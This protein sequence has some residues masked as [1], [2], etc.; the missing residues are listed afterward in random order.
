MFK[1]G[2]LQVLGVGIYETLYMTLI[3]TLMS[4][5]I[6]LPIGLALVSTDKEGYFII[7]FLGIKIPII[8]LNKLLG[9][10]VNILRSVPFLILLIAVMPVTRAIVGTTIG[11]KATI[12]PLVI[13]AAPFIARMVESSLKEVDRGVIEAAESMGASPFQI[14]FKVHLPEAKPSLLVGAAISITTILGYSAMAGIVGGG[15]LGA[16][17]MNYGYY[18]YQ[19]DIMFITVIL[20]VVIVQ[21]MQEVGMKI[22]TISDKRL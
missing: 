13:A 3:S 21:I 9:F 6:G 7:P 16:I 12:V 11:S 18:R 4:Y 2:M 1:E 10:V 20:L 22:A 5:V 8:W 17:A 14:M 19:Q 15:G